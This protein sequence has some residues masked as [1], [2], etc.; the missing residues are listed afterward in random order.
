M[1]AAEAKKGVS[2]EY[3]AKSQQY[4]DEGCSRHELAKRVQLGA[5][6]KKKGPTKMQQ[7]DIASDAATIM[8]KEAFLKK[9]KRKRLKKTEKEAYLKWLEEQPEFAKQPLIGK[10]VRVVKDS[11]PPQG[12]KL[13]L[14]IVTTSYI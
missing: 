10:E 9:E 3:I 4:I 6:M 13:L 1:R 14:L 5:K 11:F 8:D 12:L 7:K 2:A